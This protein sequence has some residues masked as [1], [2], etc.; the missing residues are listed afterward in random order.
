MAKAQPHAVPPAQPTD[1]SSASDE[2]RVPLLTK[3]VYG[4]GDWSMASFN[5]IRQIFYAIFL[6]DVVGLAPGWLHSPR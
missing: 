6:T 5:T 3:L 2:Q 1:N 4:T